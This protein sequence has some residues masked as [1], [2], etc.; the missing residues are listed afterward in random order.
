MHALKVLH[1]IPSLGPGG[2][3]RQ[4]ANLCGAFHQLGVEVHIAVLKGGPN[5]D[6]AVA[7]KAEVHCIASKSSYDAR[8]PVAICSLLRELHPDI[9]QTWLPMM[10]IL[11]GLAAWR[12]K[13]PWILTERTAPGS[14]AQTAKLRVRACLATRAAFV[15]SNSEAGNAYWKTQLPPRVGRSTIRNGLCFDEI[16]RASAASLSEF[17]FD[18]DGPL[19][20]FI[21]RIEPFKNPALVLDAMGKNVAS[22]GAIGL[23]CGSGS[24]TGR[25]MALVRERRLEDRIRFCDYTDQGISLLKRARAFVSLSHYEGMPNTVMEAA[26]SECPLVLSDIPA[27]RE[28]FSEEEAFFVETGSSAPAADAISQV[29][30]NPQDNLR[31]TEAAACKARRWSIEA[32]AESF[33]RVYELAVSGSHL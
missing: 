13:I 23:F 20:L 2:A 33:L 32:S 10:D 24:E 31:R 18:R 25:L 9:V 17:G 29:L 21:G 22:H 16:D 4:L 8:I 26:A 19:I 27:H 3:E 30:R 7:A 11:G 15:V 5:L 6:R 28:L 14:I 12:R 1:L